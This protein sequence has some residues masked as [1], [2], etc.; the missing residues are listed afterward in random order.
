MQYDYGPGLVFPDM[1]IWL[2][3]YMVIW[4]YGMVYDISHCIYLLTWYHDK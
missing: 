3:G 2:Y 1:V 4:L